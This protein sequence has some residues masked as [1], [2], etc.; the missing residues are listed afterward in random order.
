MIEM[1]L[2]AVSGAAVALA[3]TAVVLRR[4][5]DRLREVRQAYEWASWDATHD[6]LTG[7][8]NR[9]AFYTEAAAAVAVVNP[10]R[11][12]ALAIVDLDGFKTVNDTY[13]HGV[14][15]LVLVSAA[16]QLRDRVPAGMVARLGG[17]EFA[18]LVPLIAG[19]SAQT[20]GEVLTDASDGIDVDVVPDLCVTFS[21]GIVELLCPTDLIEALACADA[22]MYRA[23]QTGRMAVHHPARDDHSSPVPHQRTGVRTR[24][25]SLSRA[26]D[27]QIGAS[28]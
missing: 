26:T 19:V 4:T 21:V 16:H 17:D 15:D 13:G 2:T 12:L 8:A 28:R 20:I 9:R 25:L 18:V 23:K 14:G 3:P 11:P 6:G 7:L 27:A 10:D 5:Y 1:F 24:D 22:A